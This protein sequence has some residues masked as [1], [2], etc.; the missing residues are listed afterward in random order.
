MATSTFL[1]RSRRFAGLGAVALSCWLDSL[2]SAAGPVVTYLVPSGA[3]RGSTVTVNVGGTLGKWPVRVWS[4]RDDVQFV[5]AE[6]GKL[7]VT[8]SPETPPGVCWLR[9][10]DED[11]ASGLRPF[12]IGTVAESLEQEPNDGPDRV[13]A[14]TLPSV[15]HGQL[16][17]R[18]DV[19][20][21]AVT[22]KTGDRLV[23]ALQANRVL[24]SPMDGVLQVC[25]AEGFVLAQNDDAGGLDPLLVFN[26][27]RDGNYLVRTFAFPA[28]PDSS[29]AFAGAETFVYRL[30]LTT[31]GYLDHA[32]PF[33][34][35]AGVSTEVQLLGWNV[36]DEARRLT[37][38]PPS[39]STVRVF[40]PLLAGALDLPVVAHTTLVADA[41]AAPQPVTLPVSITGR[42]APRQV[43]RFRFPA[44]KG[45]KVRL[46]V[47]SRELGLPLDP[48]LRLL[49]AAGQQVAEVDDQG[50][51]RD[52]ELTYAPPADGTYEATVRDLHGRGG[53]RFAYRLTASEVT[54]D[55]VVRLAADTFAVARGK[56]VEIPVTIDRRD[57]FAEPLS[58]VAEAPAGCEAAP[59]ESAATGDSAK[60][61]KLTLNAKAEAASGVL[62]FFA[63]NASGVRRP[64]RFAVTGLGAEHAAAWLTVSEAQAANKGVRSIN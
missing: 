40:H 52:G 13:P 45:R 35:T 55:V 34:V 28:T 24:G 62:R 19:D 7:K 11:G 25:S 18:G 32:A 10:Y 42:L 30:T 53:D 17:K 56:S 3:A 29:I 64:V 61:V 4:E 51:A 48:V 31:S 16:A 41:A 39:G 59:V 26:A 37:L 12:V 38:P 44:V 15:V 57:G 20:A 58:I 21:F 2:A 6:K 36:P 9:L 50:T 63:T 14:V 47:E 33:A 60:A 46:R 49:D 23:A 54:P 1:H 5:A 43:D 22:L 27:P 8:V